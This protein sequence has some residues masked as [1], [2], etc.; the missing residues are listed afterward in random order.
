MSVNIGEVV[1]EGFSRTLSQNGLI[2][3]A[4]TFVLVFLNTLLTSTISA[5][6][7]TDSMAGQGQF[8]AGATGVSLPIGLPVAAVL[9][10]VVFVVS[11]VVGIGALRTFVT[12]LTEGFP[13]GAFSRRMVVATLNLLVG[14]IV[15]IVVVGIG[16][17]LLIIPGIFLLVSLY[18]WAIFV[19]VEDTNFID[20]FRGSWGL[21]R[22]TRLTLFGLGVVIVLITLVV[23][24]VL[25]I[26]Q[27]LVG[28]LVGVAIAQ[29]GTAF[30]S[31]F[32]AAATATAYNQLTA[33]ADA[34]AEP[35]E[36]P[37][38]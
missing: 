35:E 28:G 24:I 16:F 34:G 38:I 8:G 36:T 11:I 20:G 23:N 4:I 2:L 9:M 19:A 29:V 14:F 15:F 37:S 32:T 22:G 6:L 13:D 31:V 17:I 3:L 18:F 21:T 10:L 12:D 27:L 1:G 26:P 33:A 30:T 7:A 5:E 25:G